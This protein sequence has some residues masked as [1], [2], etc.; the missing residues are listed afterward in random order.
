V[1]FPYLDPCCPCN[2]FAWDQWLEDF[3][4]TEFAVYAFKDGRVRW[5]IDPDIEHNVPMADVT[6]SAEQFD[7]ILA[8]LSELKQWQKE[9]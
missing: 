3:G 2:V 7:S 4:H 5:V 8:G 6:M 9:V 1:Y